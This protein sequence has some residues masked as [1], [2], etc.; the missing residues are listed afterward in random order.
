MSLTL[1]QPDAKEL[2]R[3]RRLGFS[4]VR[5]LPKETGVRPI[6]N[7]R[8]RTTRQGG[9]RSINQLLQAAFQILT[10]EKVRE[11]VICCH[12]LLGG[13]SGAR[14][15]TFAL[16][17]PFGEPRFL[18]V[19]QH[20]GLCEAE[21]VQGGAAKDGGWQAVGWEFF[22]YLHNIVN[23]HGRPKLYFVK[24]D[25]QACF[26]TIDQMKLLEILKEI[27]SEDEYL[28]QRHGQVSSVTGKV[29]RNF[30][31]IGMPGGMCPLYR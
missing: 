23:V 17:S 22:R 30:V 19:Q 29:R 9:E 31:K 15:L 8:R 28:I 16:E 4:F 7:L 27:I 6:V 14:E 20:G 1:F 5:L 12:C 26:D 2:L 13:V 18:C 10:Y 24:V 3:Q 25:V 11:G 21:G